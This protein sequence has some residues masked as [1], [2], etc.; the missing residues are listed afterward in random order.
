[1]RMKSY[2]IKLALKCA[3]KMANVLPDE[4]DDYVGMGIIANAESDVKRLKEELKRV[5]A[6]ERADT[7][8][9]HL[10]DDLCKIRWRY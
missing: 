3:Q 8:F 9:D 2:E 4:E 6:E 7:I 1:M 10:A 5:E